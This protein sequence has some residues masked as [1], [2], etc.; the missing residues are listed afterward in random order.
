MIP[1]LLAVILLIVTARAG[2]KRI[3]VF[4]GLCDNATQGIVEVGAKIGDGNKPDDNLYWGCSDGLKSYFKASRRWKLEKR[5]TATGDERILERL[6]FRHLATKAVLVAEAWR[7]SNLKDCYL[8]SEKA[9]LSGEN[10]LVAFIGHNVLMDTAIEA[11]AKKAAGKTDAIV[12][13]C[14]SDRYFRER[15]EQAGVRPVLLTTQLMY[16]GS[17]ILHDAIEPWLTGKDRKSLRTAAGA[18]YARNQK[19][20]TAAATGVFAE[21]AP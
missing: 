8:A 10:Q 17:F 1:R 19:I 11:P 20:R 7:G 21:L 9:M 14:I 18:A 6:T 4:V 15:L 3:A 5:E 16:P 2:E 13:C 12:L